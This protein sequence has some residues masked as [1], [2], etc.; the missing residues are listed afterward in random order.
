MESDHFLQH[1]ITSAAPLRCCQRCHGSASPWPDTSGRLKAPAALVLLCGGINISSGD[2]RG[3]ALRV[4]GPFLE[5][6]PC[7]CFDWAPARPTW[8]QIRLPWN[9]ESIP[10]RIWNVG[11]GAECWQSVGRNMYFIHRPYVPIHILHSAY[12]S[13]V[14][15]AIFINSYTHYI[16]PWLYTP[17]L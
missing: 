13:M 8:N 17:Y 7:L 11:N 15:Y 1:E 2:G 3:A 16:Y 4:R 14:I 9:L 6:G 5:A 10:K 12:L